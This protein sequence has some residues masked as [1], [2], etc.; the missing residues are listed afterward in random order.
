MYNVVM[1]YVF[2]ALALTTLGTSAMFMVDI[3]NIGMVEGWAFLYNG[4]WKTNP[5]QAFHIAEYIVFGC[6]WGLGALAVWALLKPH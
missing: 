2:L 1:R 5:G 6:L 4:F 3:A